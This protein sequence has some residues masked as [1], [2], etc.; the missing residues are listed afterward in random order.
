[1]LP[2]LNEVTVAFASAIV[3]DICISLVEEVHTCSVDERADERA[4]ERIDST[5][6]AVRVVCSSLAL[7]PTAV[8]RA[9]EQLNIRC[10]KRTVVKSFVWWCAMRVEGCDGRLSRC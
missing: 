10:G 7:L 5:Q 9:T 2:P 8:L 4:D 1:M 3:L 6:P